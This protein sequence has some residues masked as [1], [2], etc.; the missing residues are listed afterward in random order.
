VAAPVKAETVLQAIFAGAAVAVA[1]SFVA[2]LLWRVPRKVLQGAALA[3]AAGGL[4]GWV[5]FAFGPTLGLGAAATGLTLCAV[6]EVGAIALAD[7]LERR[8]S[9]DTNLARAENRLSLLIE[10]EAD[11]RAEEL[12]RTLA[13]ARADTA[14]LLAEEERKNA[15]ERQRLVAERED[16]ARTELAAALSAAQQRGEE[17]VAALA[18]DLQELQQSVRI[19][20]KRLGERQAQLISEAQKRL[21]AD[22]RGIDT[23]FEQ[24]RAAVARMRTELSD[25]AE[26]AFASAK[27]EIDEHAAE[28]RRALHEVSERLRRRE[29]ELHEQIGREEIDAAQRIQAS[30]GDVERRQLDKLQRMVNRAGERYVEAAEQQFDA[31]I[32]AARDE[33]ILRLSRELER[34]AASFAREAEPILAERL[35]RMG[36]LGTQ[37]LEK[38]M[39]EGEAVLGRRRDELLTALEQ[40]FAEAEVELRRRMQTLES[41][42]EA[43][44]GILEARLQDLA[45]RIEETV[46]EAEIRLGSATR[47]S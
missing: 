22:N 8:R 5:A 44:R 4:A 35:S 38:R 23:G 13:R 19:E 1:A 17:R 46:S 34:S 42:T 40:R 41:E 30:F 36:D 7:A 18:G 16:H 32:R 14:S 27:T 31:A 26:A 39:G 9:L 10:K 33:A 2:V 15:L 12:S 20:I 29:R 6:A 45:R 43:E 37:R 28:R 11:R 21:E 47:R 3:C 24:Q 25:A